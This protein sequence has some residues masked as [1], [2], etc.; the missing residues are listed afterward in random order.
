MCMYKGVL[1]ARVLGYH[2]T[3]VA[4]CHN[5]RVREREREREREKFTDNQEVTEGR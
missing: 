2:N 1:G 3:R 5:T 4:G